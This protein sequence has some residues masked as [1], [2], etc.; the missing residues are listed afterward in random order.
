M[1]TTATTITTTKCQSMIM[2]TILIIK[3]LQLDSILFKRR[4]ILSPNKII[5]AKWLNHNSKQYRC[6]SKINHSFNSFKDSSFN[7]SRLTINKKSNEY[8][9]MIALIFNEE[10]EFLYH[11]L[12]LVLDSK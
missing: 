2:K 4:K 10:R 12:L 7:L 9:S 3:Q 5:Q 11:F 6:S 1:S 8:Q